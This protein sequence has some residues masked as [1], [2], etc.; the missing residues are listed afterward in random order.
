MIQRALNAFPPNRMKT[1]STR[2]PQ[3]DSYETVECRPIISGKGLRK[4]ELNFSGKT[5]SLDL[6]PS[7]DYVNY[8]VDFFDPPSIPACLLMDP[9]LFV[10]HYD[11]ETPSVYHQITNPVDCCDRVVRRVLRNGKNLD[12]VYSCG[13]LSVI[14][15]MGNDLYHF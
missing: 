12:M 2:L 5:C 6:D 15:E 13:F 11:G 9:V 4:V 1:Y 3:D 8:R 7:V 10:V 14:D